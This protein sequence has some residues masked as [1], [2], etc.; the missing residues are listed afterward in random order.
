ML[1]PYSTDAPIYHYPIATVSLIVVNVICFFAFGI[2]LSNSIPGGIDQFEDADGNRID[3]F[4]LIQKLKAL[5][6]DGQDVDEVAGQWTPV[7]S[8]R[9][10]WRGE[11]MLEY[12]N[13]LRPWQWL[14][15]LFMHSDLGH[16][17]GNM[18]FLWSFGLLLEGKLGWWLFG[19]V[20]L[21]MGVL[22]S[23]LEQTL[24][25]FASGGSLG[26]SS[27][28]FSLLALVVVFAPLNTFETLLFI[29]FRVFFFEVPNLAFGALY[30]AM[31]VFFFCLGGAN[32][33]SEALHLMG[34]M[35]G[36]PVGL[37]MLTRGYVDCEGYDIISHYTN[38]EGSESQVGKKEL[39]AREAKRKS[40]EN[41]MLPK[42]DQHAVRAQMA[43]QVDLAIE[44][45][46]YDLAVALQ[47]K[48][49]A[50]NPGSGWN[51]K[52]LIAVIQHYL[53]AQ[54]LAKAEP[55]LVL[56]IERFEEH[57]FPLQ[58]KLLKVWLHHQRPRHA[59]RY[60]RGL[61]P[62]FLSEAEKGELQKLADY[63]QKQI[64]TGVLETQE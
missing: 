58:T 31:N 48:I 56:H 39:K 20:Y 19:L 57:R 18:I 38:K 60:M 7:V 4:E 35:I 33:G 1:I 11:L 44:E 36:L 49:A 25:L 8:K 3:A 21:G 29:G 9:S 24:M 63:A 55:L 23:S 27:A 40:K 61:N 50:N 28:I 13:G 5:Q 30:I 54:Q 64:K 52:Q 32:F 6:A 41:A 16:L 2:G 10:D 37:F 14:T 46:N 12:G 26:A 47:G 53:K 42:I 15:S 45:G 59:L 43:S 34:F 51:Q 62:A 22:E 17:I